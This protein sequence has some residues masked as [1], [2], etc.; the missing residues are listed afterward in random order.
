MTTTEPSPQPDSQFLA[1][2]RQ[3]VRHEFTAHQQY[4]ALAVWLDQ[5]DLPQLARRFY[6]QALEER[7]HAMMMLQ[8]LIDRDVPIAVPG[9]DEVR[10][11]FDKVRDLVDLALR[12]E[13]EVTAQI[14]E[15]FKVARDEGDVIGEQFILWFLKEQL[16]EVASMRTLL[17]V[18]ERAGDGQKELFQVEEFI[19]REDARG[20]AN[21]S[22]AP[23]AAGS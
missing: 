11:D 5:R 10:N 22:Q 16:E 19:A 1:L 17:T 7:G 8:Y 9:V 12:Q 18:V 3:Q 21:D 15:L 20:G 6:A 14:E 2:L 23:K 13:L 4:V